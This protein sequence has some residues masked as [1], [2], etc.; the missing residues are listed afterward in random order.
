M[1]G[2][3]AGVEARLGKTSQGAIP[4]SKGRR[5]RKNTSVRLC[6]ARAWLG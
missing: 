4:A 1:T 6:L 3:D 5:H 2:S